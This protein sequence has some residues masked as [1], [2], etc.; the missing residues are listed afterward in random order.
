MHAALEK[1]IQ[2]VIGCRKHLAE[3]ES[4]YHTQPDI[5]VNNQP[6]VDLME[7]IQRLEEAENRVKLTCTLHQEH[8]NTLREQIISLHEKYNILHK[9]MSEIED[10]FLVN[11]IR[12]GNNWRQAIRQREYLEKEYK[13]I[14]TAI[15][16]EQYTNSR[17]IEADIQ[18]VLTHAEAIVKAAMKKS[19]EEFME[20]ENPVKRIEEV[21]VDDVFDA[22]S[23]EKLLHD[24][25]HLVLPAVHP[26]T[27]DSSP[28]AFNTAFDV[29]KK[30]DFLLMEAYLVKYRG[31]IEMEEGLDILIEL[32]QILQ[33]EEHYA[34]ILIQFQDRYDCLENDLTTQELNDPNEIQQRLQLQREE[35]L[36]NIQEE[37]QKILYWRE[38]LEGLL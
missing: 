1:Q 26:D 22:I 30:K 10:L 15:A 13:R 3:V 6:A 33:T 32:E 23:I 28:E 18:H 31:E 7:A 8:I 12:P 2:K 24:F 21:T 19:D 9:Q 25:K 29:Y 20:E 14:Q 17:D 36:A 27:S 11:V 35:I 38:K 5:E 4:R 37:A 16:Q 34:Q